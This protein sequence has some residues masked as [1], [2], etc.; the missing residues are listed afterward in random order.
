MGARADTRG[1]L[2]FRVGKPARLRAG[3][4][5]TAVGANR[6]VGADRASW[7]LAWTWIWHSCPMLRPVSRIR[8][9]RFFRMHIGGGLG[10]GDFSFD[11]PGGDCAQ[12]IDID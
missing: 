3:G 10:A 11:R 5:F 1:H 6:V 9:G 8:A 4:Q 2:R 7:R 12:W